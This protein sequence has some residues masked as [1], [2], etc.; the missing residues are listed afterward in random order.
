MLTFTVASAAHGRRGAV[1]VRRQRRRQGAAHGAAA[2][3][4]STRVGGVTREVRVELDP[5]RLQALGATA[6][7]ISRQLRQ[8]QSESLGRPHRRRRRRAA[9]A[10]ARHRAAR[11]DEIARDGDR[12]RRRPRAC[13]SDQ[14]ADGQRH[15]RRAALGGAARRQAGGRLRGRA[16]PRRERGRGRPTACASALDEAEGRAPGP[17]ARRGVQLR[18][19]RCRRSTK[20]R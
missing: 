1:L 4:R 13:A 15:R 19:R 7:D 11:R 6:A 2:S 3:A 16:Q 9:G 17:A 12:A 20:A 5:L 10:H 8:V 14:V 18:R